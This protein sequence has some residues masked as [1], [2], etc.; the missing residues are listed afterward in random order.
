MGEHTRGEDQINRGSE[1]ERVDSIH[2][3]VPD[4]G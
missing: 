1:E 4:R 3:T 2:T